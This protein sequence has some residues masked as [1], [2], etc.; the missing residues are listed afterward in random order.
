EASKLAYQNVVS[1]PTYTFE[2]FK[3]AVVRH[4]QRR[5]GVAAVSVGNKAIKIK[6]DQSRRDA[7]VVVCYE[8]RRYK[9]F[10]RE[11][12]EDYVSGI[13]FPTPTGEVINY[14]KQH[15]GNLT[16]QHQASG[17]MLKPMVRILKNIRSK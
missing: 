10:T 12:T 5:F 4:L 7:D 15:L 1:R 13:I 17:N 3:G 6:G 8:Y 14:P 2:D 16:K 9:S 11:K